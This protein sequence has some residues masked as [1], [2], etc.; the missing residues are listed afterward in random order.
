[1]QC[2]DRELAAEVR[3]LA[4]LTRFEINV[5]EVHVPHLALQPHERTAAGAEGRGASIH[6]AASGTGARGAPFA[7][8][9]LTEKVGP[10]SASP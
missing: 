8:T 7:S 2:P 3:E 10:T 4:L 9:A 6:A 1:M 5:P